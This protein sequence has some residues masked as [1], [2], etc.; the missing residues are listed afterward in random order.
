MRN[1]IKGHE[2]PWIRTG[3]RRG[4]S[5]HGMTLVEVMM[6][7]S[8]LVVAA[9]GALH[10]QYYVAGHGRLAAATMAAA[11]TA[12]LLLEDW[13][14]TGGSLEYDPS[15]LELGFSNALAIPAGFTA[16]EGLGAALND[17]AYAIGINDIP[18]LVILKYLDVNDD[19]QA[20]ATLRQL[21]A[22]VHF[23]APGDDDSSETRFSEMPPVT[24]V[25]YVRLDASGG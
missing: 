20:A 22:V 4:R 12:Q 1:D 16:P 13:K 11:N 18:M 8:I 23:E 3:G 6:A 21:A 9:L 17:A 7:A 10:C 19:D 5:A 15:N 2:A 14:S 24:L 25:T